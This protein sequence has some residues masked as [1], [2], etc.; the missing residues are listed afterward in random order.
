MEKTP[1]INLYVWNPLSLPHAVGQ[2]TIPDLGHAAL[3]V[4]G[5]ENQLSGYVS[6]WPPTD[7]LL[8][9]A[10]APFKKRVE[11]NPVS[12]EEES[13]PSGGYMQR[14]ADYMEPLVGLNQERILQEWERFKES[15][16]DLIQWNCSDV[17]RLLLLRAMPVTYAKELVSLPHLTVA[18]L[19][20]IQSEEEMWQTIRFLATSSFIHS[21]PDDVLRIAREYNQRWQTAQQEHET[22]NL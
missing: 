6:F 17:C 9:A 7:D 10:L 13:D 11:R 21:R 2:G 15:P 16:Y 22:G 5:G 14:V 20:Q 1:I 3:E 12:Y 18:D 4:V 8:G 19:D